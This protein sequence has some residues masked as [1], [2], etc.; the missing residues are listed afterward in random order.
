MRVDVGALEREYYAHDRHARFGVT[1]DD[2][3]MNRCG[4]APTRQQ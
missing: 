3:T 2:R 4:T 1:G